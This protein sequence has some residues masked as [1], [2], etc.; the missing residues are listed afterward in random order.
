MSLLWRPGSVPPSFCK[1][2][3]Q[4]ANNKTKNTKL[5]KKIEEALGDVCGPPP[6]LP[7]QL[8]LVLSLLKCQLLWYLSWSF[9]SPYCGTC[10]QEFSSG[11]WALSHPHLQ[12]SFSL[13]FFF[14]SW[15]TISLRKRKNVE[16]GVGEGLWMFLFSV[17]GHLCKM[18]VF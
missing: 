2:G 5:K 17:Q 11:L 12:G 13:F 16:D 15:N 18:P 3:E 10:V 7:Q 9:I 6:I 4:K 8:L 14:F 1:F